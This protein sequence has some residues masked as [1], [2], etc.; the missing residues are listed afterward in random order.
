[1]TATLSTRSRN[2]RTTNTRL[3][4]SVLD[5]I[6]LVAAGP[7]R[8]KVLANRLAMAHRDRFGLQ[9]GFAE[10]LEFLGLPL[11]LFAP[12]PNFEWC[13]G[14]LCRGTS[15]YGFNDG[16]LARQ[17]AIS[18]WQFPPVGLSRFHRYTL[19]IEPRQSKEVSFASASRRRDFSVCNEVIRSFHVAV[20]I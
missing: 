5:L 3:L 12:S 18:Q 8:F 20:A 14:G 16:S 13:S 4:L 1:M 2:R 7:N 15:G 11:K 17:V 6:D 9:G 10:A 19:R